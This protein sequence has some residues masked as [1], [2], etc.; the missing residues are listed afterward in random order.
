MEKVLLNDELQ[1]FTF[2]HYAP[3]RRRNKEERGYAGSTR[4]KNEKFYKQF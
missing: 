2:I 4:R 1:I 3:L